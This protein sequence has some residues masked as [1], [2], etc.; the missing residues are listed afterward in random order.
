MA[1]VIRKFQP[2]GKLIRDG[3]E[4]VITEDLLNDILAQGNAEF[5]NEQDRANVGRIVSALRSGNVTIDSANNTLSGVN[6]ELNN[7]RQKRRA[8]KKTTGAGQAL[9]EVFGAGKVNSAKNVADWFINRFAYKT[10]APTE[11]EDTRPIADHTAKLKL[12][13]ITNDDSTRTLDKSAT[14]DQIKRRL[15]VMFGKSNED[16]KE[17]K[18]YKGFDNWDAQLGYIQRSGMNYDNL[19]NEITSGK[20]SPETLS[21][22][23]SIGIFD[24]DS[25]EDTM[26]AEERKSNATLKSA[27]L[28]PEKTQE[29]VTVDKN[30]RFLLSNEFNEQLRNAGINDAWFNDYW[31]KQNK[32]VDLNW[33]H[34]YVKIGNYLYKAD[35]INNPNSELY[36]LLNKDNG[37]LA[38]MRANN[39]SGADSTM[40][41]LWGKP[42]EFESYNPTSEYNAW[43]AERANPNFRYRSET[44]NYVLENGQQILSYFDGTERDVWGQPTLK[45]ALFDKDGNF[46]QDINDIN[47]YTRIEDENV[48]PVGFRGVHQL[49]SDENSPYYGYYA[50][51]PPT[52]NG[53]NPLTLYY[54]SKDPLDVIMDM[55]LMD[56]YKRFKGK[57]IRLPKEFV[58]ELQRNPYF[59]DNLFGQKQ[60]QERFVKLLGQG[61]TSGFADFFN[62]DFEAGPR[63]FK[64][65]GFTPEA[66]DRLTNIFADW[67]DRNGKSAFE[68]QDKRLVVPMNQKGG[69]VGKSVASVAPNAKPIKDYKDPTKTAGVHDDW[70]LSSA[71]KLQ[72]ASIA[73]DV[74]SLVAAIPT[75]GNPVAATIGAGSTL[76]QFGADVKRDGFD[77]GDVGNLALGLG[78]DA[79]SL[80][81][82]VGIAA[83]TAKTAKRIKKAYKI[84]KPILL[85]IGAGNAVAG[86][87]NIVNGNATLDDWKKLSTG[88]LAIKGIGDGL[89]RRAAIRN[90]TDAPEVKST[91]VEVTNKTYD[92]A[93][94]SLKGDDK[95]KAVKK[96]VDDVVGENSDL[97]K[98]NG[99]DVSWVSE[100][101]VSN[102]DE[103]FKALRE[104]GHIKNEDINAA[105]PPKGK[106]KTAPEKGKV[107]WK[108]QKNALSNKSKNLMEW[109]YPSLE[110]RT[111]KADVDYYNLPWY[112]RRGLR[113]ARPL[114]PDAYDALF[115]IKSESVVLPKP[116]LTDPKKMPFPP[117]R[118]TKTLSSDIKDKML[119][120]VD[121]IM[122]A[123]P[124]SPTYS[125]SIL[126]AGSMSFI[127]AP[128]RTLDT[129]MKLS[130]GY[131]F[132]FFKKGGII[133]GK[134]GIE[135][136]PIITDDL[137]DKMHS[138]LKL[139]YISDPK[140][141]KD[142][143]TGKE[144]SNGLKQYIGQIFRGDVTNPS[145]NG[146]TVQGQFIQKPNFDLQ[147]ITD[148]VL[149]GVEA[150]IVGN[151]IKKQGELAKKA[152]KDSVEILSKQQIPQK[153][154]LR[155][156]NSAIQRQV[157]EGRDDIMSVRNTPTTDVNAHNAFKL[158]QSEQ[159]SNLSKNALSAESEYASKL[160]A[161]N[162]QIEDENTAL[163]IEGVN[164][165]KERAATLAQTLPQIDA[166]VNAQKAHLL[167]SLVSEE[168]ERRNRDELERIA[169]ET[170]LSQAKELSKY[171]SAIDAFDNAITAD[172]EK[173]KSNADFTKSYATLD[174]YKNAM[175]EKY[176]SQLRDLKQVYTV[177]SNPNMWAYIHGS[178]RS[179]FSPNR[180]FEQ[181]PN[182]FNI[183]F[184]GWT[185]STASVSQTGL[186]YKSGGNLPKHYSRSTEQQMKID[187][188]KAFLERMKQDKEHLFKLLMK[189][190]S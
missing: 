32:D 91:K 138:D 117:I 90:L 150:G 125:H 83:K 17:H 15:E 52:H 109:M 136:K 188:H 170:S 121:R 108:N 87:T 181:L 14:N 73:G 133:K 164:K 107:W 26:S 31:L 41:W 180:E 60:A 118:Y 143:I 58:K 172:Y 155:Y 152:A 6:F 19:L 5:D 100:G 24:G 137:K 11:P 113:Y 77:F 49:I 141:I 110:G 51:T 127:K 35:D 65:M 103:A 36:D 144:M 114:E 16:F 71:D 76:A 12:S 46:I 13:Y 146:T 29:Y 18:A 69:L 115:G 153:Q 165:Q 132:R 154:T 82:G 78:L 30:G 186:G 179:I 185:P 63:W 151:S 171:Q 112:Y 142:P 174:A 7:E 95:T 167:G 66:A 44:A 134:K 67:S 145:A 169:A 177:R 106:I 43:L 38:N 163:R 182:Y 79:V 123:L 10:P 2:G 126:P 4:Q 28:D 178:N 148:Q 54:N 68:R 75:G 119:S 39:F 168:R 84:L 130:D 159:L 124:I 129:S 104:S 81:P 59:F 92:D 96:I 147:G 72:I 55:S 183:G 156:D 162:Q 40:K 22:L 37:F 21:F 184:T 98:F 3:K 93:L 101:K 27:G 33:L 1:Q 97:K 189:L 111:L 135:Y 99:S 128:Y 120:D 56:N 116:K 85:G 173:H 157:K 62:D 80:L 175:Y 166:S 105:L 42:M 64:K 34:G 50:V 122:S 160:Q 9:D 158:A 25:T 139:G 88:L 190:L 86:L 187:S 161:Q 131:Q 48:N 70:N 149:R 47:A 53:E 176:A 20:I 74:A 61:V 94:N 89:K 45:Y 140:T 57:N 8:N 102:Y 23:N